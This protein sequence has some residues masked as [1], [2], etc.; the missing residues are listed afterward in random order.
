MIDISDPT[1]MVAKDAKDDFSGGGFTELA[2]ASSVDTFVIGSSTYA[3]VASGGN[4][5]DDGVQIIDISDVDN[6]VA[7]DAE[8]DGVNGFT[9]LDGPQDVDAFTCG[10]KTYAIVASGGD[11]GVQLIDLSDPANIVA[12]DAETDGVGGFDALAGAYNVEAFEIDDKPY[13]LVAG[14]NDDSVQM[15][16]MPCGQS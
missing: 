15:I 7:T 3:I 10:A 8:T 16:E 14:Y 13:A 11:D 9:E 12:T 5:G 4:S 1:D 6:I 2:Y